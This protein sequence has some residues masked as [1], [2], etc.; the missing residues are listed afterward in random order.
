MTALFLCPENRG[1]MYHIP[2]ATHLRL[3]HGEVPILYMKITTH[4]GDR[5][6]AKKTITMAAIAGSLGCL[7][8][9]LSFG[10]FERTLSPAK[11]DLLTAYSRKQQ[12][13]ISVQLDNAD[14]YFSALLAQEPFLSRNLS[15]YVGFEDEAVANHIKIFSGVISEA[16]VL[17]ILTLEASEKSSSSPTGV[18]LDDMFYLPTAERYSNPLNIGDRLPIVYGDLRF[19]I[20]GTWVAP[21]ID[22]V[23]FVYCYAS[24]PVMTQTDSELKVYVGDDPF[25]K[26]MGVDYVFNPSH[27]F[28]PPVP[29]PAIHVTSDNIATITFMTDQG[30]QVVTVRG[31]GK[32][33]LPVGLSGEVLIDNPIDVID[34]F[35]CAENDF[36]ST[37]FES[38]KKA[39]SRQKIETFYPPNPYWCS[40][41]AGVLSQDDTYW[42]IIT[43]MMASFLG[44]AYLNGEGKLVLEVD[45]GTITQY[46]AGTPP[47]LPKQ[48][49]NLIESKLRLLNV[50][51]ECPCELAFD[52]IHN[53]FYWTTDLLAHRGGASQ[54]IY[55][56]RK[57]GE[58]YKFYWCRELN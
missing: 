28:E 21:C 47:T 23:N 34:D 48:E 56:I 10:S 3:E 26:I 37:L 57:P 17:S 33:F 58:T 44:S 12:Q 9:V 45:D 49:T 6:Y 32:I 55:G 52:Y 22:T 35:L 4:L 51:N 16:S 7:A 25:P 39:E 20:T 50:I 19:G 36:T 41:C 24:H 5:V 2:I 43:S 31:K 53:T 46:S 40:R 30:T 54:G 14:G 38:T 27:Y 42:N 1:I 11:D 8:R 18:T 15:I 29:P 13:H